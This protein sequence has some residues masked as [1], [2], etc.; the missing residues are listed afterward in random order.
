MYYRWQKILFA[1]IMI[2]LVT[3]VV[4]YWGTWISVVIVLAMLQAIP[5]HFNRRFM[6]MDLAE[7]FDNGVNVKG[8]Q[9]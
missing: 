1:V 6:D 8:W 9:D 2:T 3:L 7:Q 4:V 5:M